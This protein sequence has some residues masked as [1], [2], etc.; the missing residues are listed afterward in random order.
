MQSNPHIRLLERPEY[1]RRWATTPWEAQQTQALRDA[2]L[3]RLERAELWRDPHGAVTLSIAQLAD[4]TRD[5]DVL[6]SV[7]ELLAGTAQYDPVA[8]LTA[9]LSGEAVPFLAAY[10]YKD[11]GLVKFREWQ[12]VWELQRREDAGHTVTIPVPPKYAQADFRSTSF[13]RARG[14]LDVPK[15]RFIAYPGVGRAGDSSPV[16]G[17]AG[18]DHADQALALARAVSDQKSLG[19]DDEALVPLLAGLAELEPWLHQWHADVDP[20]RGGSPAQ[21]VTGMLEHELRQLDRTRSDLD[22]W[23]PPAATRGRKPGA[24]NKAGQ[25]AQTMIDEVTA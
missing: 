23:R 6:R 9:L 13:W 5:D 25:S 24:K 1:K 16:L 15:E 7:L 2:A 11:S 22:A 18:W 20:A 21:A 3:D 19:A 12:Q 8:T 10:R 14:K 4:L 17:W